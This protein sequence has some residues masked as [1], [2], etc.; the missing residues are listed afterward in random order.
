MIT[1]ALDFDFK[2]KLIGYW[3]NPGLSCNLCCTEVIDASELVDVNDKDD[4]DYL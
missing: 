2:F 4:Y 3:N 1:Y